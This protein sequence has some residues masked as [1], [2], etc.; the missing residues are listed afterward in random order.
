MKKI[1]LGVIFIFTIALCFGQT[2]SRSAKSG[3]YVTKEYSSK[4]PS[5]TVNEGTKSSKGSA[6]P[7]TS[8]QRRKK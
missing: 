5:T 3:K 4:H 8:S 2:R 7:K 6:A 1:T